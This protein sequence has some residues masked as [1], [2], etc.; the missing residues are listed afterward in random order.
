[1]MLNPFFEHFDRPEDENECYDDS[2]STTVSGNQRFMELM[3]GKIDENA[4][5]YEKYFWWVKLS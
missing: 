3:K 2:E 1:M 5:Y 4:I